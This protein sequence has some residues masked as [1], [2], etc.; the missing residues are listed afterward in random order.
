MT[1]AHSPEIKKIQI[2]ERE[3]RNVRFL[4]NYKYH[5]PKRQKKE[6]QQ[7]QNINK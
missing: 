4:H 3:I 1:W 5:P 7:Q 2:K 6:Q